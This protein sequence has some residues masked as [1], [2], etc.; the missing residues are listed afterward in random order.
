MRKIRAFAIAAT[1][2]TAIAIPS[3]ADAATVWTSNQARNRIIFK[4][5]SGN[6]WA[7]N[8]SSGTLGLYQCHP[9]WHKCPKLGDI[10]AQHKWGSK[11]MENRYGTWERALRF[12]NAHNWW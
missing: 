9:R 6:P 1:A 7:V 10:K 12:H 5:S 4:E 11:Y 8:R 3:T 2:A